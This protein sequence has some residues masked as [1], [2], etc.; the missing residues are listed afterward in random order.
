MCR[1]RPHLA[2]PRGFQEARPRA[3]ALR[4]PAE[5]A[6]AAARLQGKGAVRHG[7]GSAAPRRPRRAPGPLTPALR[8]HSPNPAAGSG[9]PPGAARGPQQQQQAQGAALG[10]PG[11][12]GS[13]GLWRP[14]GCGGQAARAAGLRSGRLERMCSMEKGQGLPGPLRLAAAP[15]AAMPVGTRHHSRGNIYVGGSAP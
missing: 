5:A 9:D 2:A 14:A 1:G 8:T 12:L 6:T 11:S 13:T 3:G 7:A 4:T 15:A 10:A